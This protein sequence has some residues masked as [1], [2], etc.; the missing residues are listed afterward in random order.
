MCIM[1]SA[2]GSVKLCAVAGAGGG[3]GETRCGS[4]ATGHGP[5]TIPRCLP[6][7]REKA[8]SLVTMK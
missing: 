3:G 1:D 6:E 7:L 5:E 8:R 4:D 2:E